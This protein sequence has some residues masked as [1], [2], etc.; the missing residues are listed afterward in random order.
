MAFRNDT[1][2]GVLV[3]TRFTASTPG[4]QGVLTV[5]LWSTKHFKVETSVSERSNF[6]DPPT[7]Y[8]SKDN[9]IPNRVGSRGFSITSY[10]EVWE[11]DGTLVKDEAYPW[12]YRP[13]PVVVCGEE[14]EDGDSD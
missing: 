14:P 13:N 11:P 9:C 1:P 7:I 10:R 2:Y 8:N 5:R 3:D 4:S 12:T 6:T